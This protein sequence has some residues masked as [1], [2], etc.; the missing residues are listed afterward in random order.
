MKSLVVD[1]ATLIYGDVW[2]RI[3]RN[4]G[5]DESDVL[6]ERGVVSP[7]GAEAFL[8]VRVAGR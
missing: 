3:L 7:D 6:Q 4:V 5:E 2:I 8:D 1:E